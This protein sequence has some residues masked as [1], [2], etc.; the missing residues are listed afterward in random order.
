[1]SQSGQDHGIGIVNLERDMRFSARCPVHM[2]QR[3]SECSGPATVKREISISRFTVTA[4]ATGARRMRTV[5][6]IGGSP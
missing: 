3:Y 5:D 1:M 2:R 6:D 4:G